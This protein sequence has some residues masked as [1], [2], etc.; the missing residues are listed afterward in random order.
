MRAPGAISAGSPCRPPC[1]GVGQ[2]GRGQRQQI[3][4]RRRL[5][6]QL[7]RPPT[8]L[9]LSCQVLQLGMLHGHDLPAEQ[10]CLRGRHHNG[11]PA[12]LVPRPLWLLMLALALFKA[13]LLALVGDAASLLL[14]LLLLLLQRQRAH[15]P[16]GAV[17]LLRGGAD[18]SLAA[19]HGGQRGSKQSSTLGRRRRQVSPSSSFCLLLLLCCS[20][21]AHDEGGLRAQS[22]TTIRRGF[23]LLYVRL[24]A[25][26]LALLIAVLL[27]LCQQILDT[28]GIAWHR[29]TLAG[30]R[31]RRNARIAAST[32]CSLG[33][34][35]RQGLGLR[36][37]SR[38]ACSMILPARAIA[39]QATCSFTASAEQD[40]V[41]VILE[42][43][44]SSS[45]RREELLGRPSE[46]DTAGASLASSRLL[47]LLQVHTSWCAA[48]AEEGR[49]QTT[50]AAPS[51]ALG[52]GE[53]HER[54]L[55]SMRISSER[56][57]GAA[58]GL[59]AGAV[60]VPPEGRA[61]LLQPSVDFLQR[62]W[63]RALHRVRRQAVRPCFRIALH[64]SL[65]PPGCLW[66]SVQLELA[67]SRAPSGARGRQR[68]KSLPLHQ[69]NTTPAQEVMTG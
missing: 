39:L 62:L 54:R 44:A 36:Q 12:V 69:A 34:Q 17:G 28:C 22:T 4:C 2:Q 10:L 41:V 35:Q 49:W 52:L 51:Q 13:Q 30:R 26:L 38:S 23:E 1:L 25:L 53:E 21:E 45:A 7:P 63:M 9:L 48:A 56:H 42:H 29:L 59:L 43:L 47:E 8:L 60:V 18:H 6:Q 64:G 11:I 14:L 61:P 58:T 3:A 40:C 32:R 24:L 15:A 5:L 16:N 31:R 27:Q 19:W 46:R 20:C 65:G 66:F 57:H 37:A 67:E 50:I 55:R 33:C 68:M